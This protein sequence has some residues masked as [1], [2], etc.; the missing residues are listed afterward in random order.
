MP[1]TLEEAA[2]AFYAAG[3]RLLA[4]DRRDVEMA[5]SLAGGSPPHRSFLSG[6]PAGLSPCR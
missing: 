4:D 2:D 3:N 1:T 5:G 6:G